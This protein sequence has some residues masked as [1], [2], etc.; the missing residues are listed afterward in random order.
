MPIVDF[1]RA[2]SSLARWQIFNAYRLV[3][4]SL[5]CLVAVLGWH[6]AHFG[7]YLP[8][9]FYPAVVCYLGFALVCLLLTQRRIGR[10]TSQVVCCT[11]I[12]IGFLL[13][14]IYVSG[15]VVSGLPILLNVTLAGCS[16][17][18]I[19]RLSF[20]F[21]A[22]AS[23]G[24]FIEQFFCL[25]QTAVLTDCLWQVGLF[26][27]SYFATTFLCS[28]LAAKLRKTEYLAQTQKIKI[29]QFETYMTQQAQQ[30]KLASLGR[31]TA[32]IAHE[33]RNPLGAVG[34]AGQLLKESKTLSDEEQRLTEI[35]VTNVTRMNGVIKNVLQLSRRENTQAEAFMLKPW[36]QQFVADLHQQSR[37][38]LDIKLEVATD[39]LIV[40]MDVSQLHQVLTNVCEN[41]LRYSKRQQGDARLHLRAGILGSTRMAYLDVEDFGAGIPLE[42]QDQLF[43]PFYTSERLGTGLGLY[44]AKELCEA[45]QAQLECMLTGD[46]GTCFRITLPQAQGAL[47]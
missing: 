31:L 44:I 1:F 7:Q 26:G 46:T 14:F 13:L 30:L 33:L 32:S 3:L 21:A 37:E 6:G 5:F 36:L 45:N 28:S 35:I 41:G 2:E 38:T 12:D 43:E 39:D 23:L 8:G 18:L 29:E 25:Q 24:L 19:G 4:A 22:F 16:L 42:V 47:G 10:L 17:L 9:V 15:G 34:Y 20:A 27:A 11:A 40:K